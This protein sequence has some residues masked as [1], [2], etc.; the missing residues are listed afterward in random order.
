MSESS[1]GYL[2]K[3]TA[4]GDFDS[5][6]PA[7]SASEKEDTSKTLPKGVVLG[8]DGKPYVASLSFPMLIFRVDVGKRYLLRIVY[9]YIYE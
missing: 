4:Q 8:K 2:S 1:R 7:D 6:A 9:I 3:D 5:R